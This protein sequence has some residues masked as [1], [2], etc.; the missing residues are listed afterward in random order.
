MCLS[1]KK[2]ISSGNLIFFYCYFD[3]VINGD[4]SFSIFVRSAGES[5]IR[6]IVKYSQAKRLNS[7]HRRGLIND[8]EM[9]TIEE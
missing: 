9:L 8:S 5:I 4:F 1:I 3:E 2:V 6:N 7:S